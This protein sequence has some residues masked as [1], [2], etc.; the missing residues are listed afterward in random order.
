MSSESIARGA[1]APYFARPWTAAAA[2]GL[3]M[4]AILLVFQDTALEMVGI[5]RRMETFN[6]GF[7]VLPISLWLVWGKRAELASIA[8]RPFPLGGLLIAAAGFLWL[9]GSLADA[10]VVQQFA[11]VLMIQGVVPT[12]CGLVI[13]RVVLFPILFLFFAVPF[14]DALVPKLMDWTADFTVFG[15]RLTG[16][17]V[18]R[19]GNN[20]VIPSGHWSVV[21]A[22]SGIRY[23]IS[24][25]MAGA[26]YA[27]L[28]YRSI[29]KRIAFVC[30]AALVPIA[31]NWL[32][33]YLIVMLGH[34]SGNELAAGVD[35][36]IYGWIF[37]GVVMLAMFWFGAHFREDGVDSSPPAMRLAPSFNVGGL[38]VAAAVAVGSAALW[39]P[40]AAAMLKGDVGGP[41]TLPF[42]NGVSGWIAQPELPDGTWKPH[43][44]GY[45]AERYQAFEKQGEQV[46]VGI[47]YYAGQRQ[48]QEL[49]N[50]ENV[51]VTTADSNWREVSRGV[52]RLPDGAMPGQVRV[53]KL[54]G[55][56]GQFD[57]AWWYWVPGSTTTSDAVAK[58]LLAWSRLR[59]QGDA[60]AA[61]FL[62]AE[63]SARSDGNELLRR[64][65]VDMGGEIEKVLTDTHRA[66]R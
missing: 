24:S 8:V 36:L 35:H 53:A 18:Y 9:L 43:F 56:R 13:A 57:I 62:Y 26:L 17:P 61:V 59:L 16:V 5:W 14:G 64:F 52:A 6:H 50:H 10:A 12:I 33:A 32:R 51:L 41:V 4:A 30:A 42:V 3:A 66:T 1:N 22:C 21:E 25:L 15:L 63:P 54:S 19:E 39:P 23:L 44:S 46:L 49:V 11:L 7:L 34:L 60:S 2:C 65:A 37:F 31:A 38:V 47:L 55:A 27:Y 48:G 28:M 58:W 45:R 29:W 40:I 20:F